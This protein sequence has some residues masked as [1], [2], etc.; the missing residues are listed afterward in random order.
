VKDKI[1]LERVELLLATK[2]EK[3][4]AVVKALGV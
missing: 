3:Y 1:D 2:K 4:H